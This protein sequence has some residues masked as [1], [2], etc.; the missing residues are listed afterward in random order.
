IINIATRTLAATVPFGPCVEA[1]TSPVALRAVALNS[2]FAENIHFYSINGA[3][4]SLEGF[5]LTG[6]L[7][8]GDA[9]RV[10]AMTPNGQKLVVCQNTSRNVAI[11]NM[12]T[13]TV[14]AYVDVGDR[15]LAAAVTPNGQHAVVC[16]SD[17][18]VVRVIDLSTNTIVA[19]L[20]IPGRPAQVR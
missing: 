5:A 20:N 17:S 8:E 18:D 9:A 19:S 14:Q 16:A 7:P 13:R 2:R 1:A 15:P 11:V 3:A 4:S 12:V 10:L 6:A